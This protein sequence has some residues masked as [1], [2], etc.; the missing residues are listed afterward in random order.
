MLINTF[1]LAEMIT[2]WVLAR[3]W[4]WPWTT[5]VPDTGCARRMYCSWP[6]FTCTYTQST[7][8]GDKVWIRTEMVEVE[9][10]T[11]HRS[12]ISHSK[13]IY[14]LF[15]CQIDSFWS[16]LNIILYKKW[17]AISHWVDK[18]PLALNPQWCAVPY[19]TGICWISPVLV[20][21]CCMTCMVWPWAWAVWAEPCAAAA[22]TI[23][24]CWPSPTC[25]AT[26]AL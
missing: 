9:V 13:S 16:F 11:M 14:G 26:G 8:G 5:C 18:F 7:Q 22:W 3:V 1:F 21:I 2:C 15:I 17:L 24:T 10:I 19:L 23:W 4:I 20:M 25:M 6:V 12:H